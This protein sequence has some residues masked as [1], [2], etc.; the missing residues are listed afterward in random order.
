[1]TH[2]TQLRALCHL[3]ESE[4]ARQFEYMSATRVGTSAH[5]DAAFKAW[6]CAM[7]ARLRAAWA[8]EDRLAAIDR[9]CATEG[10]SERP[11]PGAME[12]APVPSI[13]GAS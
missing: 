8:L 2:V 13:G 4:H 5:R 7:D 6:Q 9:M 12:A 3:Y 10:T 11:A 1:M